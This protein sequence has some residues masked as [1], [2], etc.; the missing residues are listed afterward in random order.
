MSAKAYLILFPLLALTLFEARAQSFSI[1][2]PTIGAGAASVE[3]LNAVSAAGRIKSAQPVSLDAI[4]NGDLTTG[5]II[6][7]GQRGL[8]GSGK[9]GEASDVMA[10]GVGEAKTLVVPDPLPSL[11][12]NG[13]QRYLSESTGRAVGLFGYS[14]F[15]GGKGAFTPGENV[16]ASSDY[17]VGPGDEVLI[18]A[19]GGIDI[20]IREVVDRNGQISLPKVGTFSVNGVKVRELEDHIRSKIARVYRNFDLNVTLGQ[21]RSIQIYVVGNAR[22]PGSYYV[23]GLSSLVHGLFS[24]G[25]PSAAGSMR[26]VQL[27]RNG[28][29]VADLDLYDFLVNGNKTADVRLQAGDVI[30]IPP[31]GPRVALLGATSSEAIYE[32]DDRKQNNLGDLLSLTGSRLEVTTSVLSAGLERVDPSRT[33]SRF[34]EQLVLN[35]AGLKVSLKDGDIVTLYPI[36]AKFENLVVLSR[37]GTSGVRLPWRQG[38]KVR[39]L[40]ER[41]VILTDAYW[42]RL[43]QGRSQPGPATYEVNWEYATIQRL[44]PQLLK[45][46]L[47]AFRLDRALAGDQIENVELRAGDVINLY[48]ANEV[49]PEAQNSIAIAGSLFGQAQRFPWRQ[50]I[51]V[52]DILRDEVWLTERYDYW[53]KAISKDATGRIN[54]D[55]ASVQRRQPQSLSQSMLVFNLWNA[56]K[57]VTVKDNLALE[58]GDVITL[59]TSQDIALPQAKRTR[60]AT[61]EGEVGAAGIYQLNE[62]ETLRQLLLRAGG[63]TP[64]AY[65]FGTVFTRNSIRVQQQERLDK[66]ISLFEQRMQAEEAALAMDASLATEAGAQKA[67]V[68]AAGMKARQDQVARLK[69]QKA[70]GR[71]ALELPISVSKLVELPDIQ[72]EEGDR[73]HIPSYNHYVMAVGAVHN[74]NSILWRS[75]RTVEEV[76]DVAGLSEGADLDSAFLLRA[77][78]TVVSKSQSRGLFT[79]LINTFNNTELMPGDVVVVPEKLDKGSFWGNFVVGLKDWSQILYQFGLGVAAWKNL[80]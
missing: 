3:S 17:V 68:L 31:A 21:L 50:G 29:L 10:G 76:I 79:S 6:R 70:M 66:A 22:K 45:T 47:L 78:G 75:G 26:H 56:I 72:L 69:A 27:K 32:L 53:N 24:A 60:M 11:V 9:R 73:I 14:L 1:S 28:I 19:W 59:Y 35:A 65:L 16:A 51:K 57:G 46:E 34:I 71:L 52:K 25:G 40:L 61:V 15:E 4:R 80:K 7:P 64:Q 67:R 63:V 30:V 55:Y 18:R 41:D 58:P 2:P 13:F 8:A 44:D 37:G 20:E 23:S 42:R 62:G 77:D 36:G 5:Q 49:L 12:E 48:S 54:W 74:D 43:M 39:D 33:P 38:M